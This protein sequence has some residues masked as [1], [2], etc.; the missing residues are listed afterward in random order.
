MDWWEAV[1][2][3]DSLVST[4]SAVLYRMSCS[5][6]KR[7]KMTGFP[8]FILCTQHNQMASG[9]CGTTHALVKSQ[10]LKFLLSWSQLLFDI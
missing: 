10:N 2:D 4:V 7:L 3:L 8:Y 1:L 5:D 9:A 6:M